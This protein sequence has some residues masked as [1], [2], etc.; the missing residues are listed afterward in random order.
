MMK[1]DQV[2]KDEMGRECSTWEEDGYIENFGEKSR[3]KI[4]RKT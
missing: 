1:N 4:T 2:R 3:R